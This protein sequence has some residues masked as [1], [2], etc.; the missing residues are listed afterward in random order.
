MNGP[1]PDIGRGAFWNGVT[2]AANQV[3]RFTL[4]MALARLVAP[5]ELGLVALGLV[6]VDLLQ[7]LATFGIGEA[8]T[9]QPEL[10]DEQA[11]TACWLS[12]G[13]G[14]CVTLAVAIA[15]PAIAVMAGKPALGPVIASLSPMFL[16]ASLQI[17]HLARM[18]REFRFREIALRML[19][20][21]L[22]GG[23]V[24]LAL[25][26]KGLGVWALVAR[27]LTAPIV[28]T[29]FLWIVHPWR[30][31]MRFRTDAARRQLAFGGR[32]IGGEIVL[33]LRS[34]WIDLVAG[35]MLAPAALGLLRVGGQCA[36]LLL[37]LTMMPFIHLAMPILSRAGAQ[38]SA[39]SVGTE[40][41][42]LAHLS[43]A[44]IFPAFFGMAAVADLLLPLMLGP[45]WAAAAEL[46]PA[47]CAIAVPLQLTLLVGP[48]LAAAGRPGEAL[49]WSVVQLA[50]TVP[51][52]LAGAWLGLPYLVW[53]AVIASALIVPAGL[54]RL[55]RVIQVAPGAVVAAATRPLLA[56]ALMAAAVWCGKTWL[57]GVLPAAMTLG[58]CV[59]LGAAMYAALSIT[60]DP[61]LIVVF[62]ASF[63]KK[64][65][66]ES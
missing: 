26:F 5:A 12:V 22:V 39:R 43:A 1:N 4:F 47:L 52:T 48:A 56:A 32:I 25:A 41:L 53:S 16:L 45:R 9:Q 44:T 8:V 58:V 65:P 21:N 62:R 36:L 13:I 31:R 18:A 20:A 27:S 7:A 23:G 40:Y 42:T 59:M 17:V 37:E 30:P 15:S 3:I 55:R 38:D 6:I 57:A 50:V 33:V 46:M 61:D 35:L 60:I 63:A 24:G 54:I 29:I 11:S 28:A 14:T 66:Q 19:V 49:R 34:R 2:A 51:W 10:D 64:M